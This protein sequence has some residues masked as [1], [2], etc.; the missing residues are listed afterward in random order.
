M[1]KALKIIGIV[2]LVFFVIGLFMDD[3]I[4]DKPEQKK[5]VEA[6]NKDNTVD[7]ASVYSI[8][9]KNE[10]KA[11]SYFKGQTFYV[12]GVVTRIAKDIANDPYITLETGNMIGSVQCMMENEQDIINLNIGDAVVVR[13]KCSGKIMNVLFRNCTLYNN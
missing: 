13:G 1:K 5:V 2:L 8:Y 11:D 7:A 4:P 10:V 12:T 6:P 3:T 9:E